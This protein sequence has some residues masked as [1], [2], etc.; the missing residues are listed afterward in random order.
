MIKK[1]WCLLWGH[2]TLEKAYTGQTYVATNLLGQPHSVS[3][4]RWQR[5]DFC[6]RCGNDVKH[7][8]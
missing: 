7:G 3:F 5:F 8:K 1:M 2:Q 6:L 4:Y